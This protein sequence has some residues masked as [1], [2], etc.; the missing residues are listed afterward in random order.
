MKFEKEK[1]IKEDNLK[2]KEKKDFLQSKL[3]FSG[4]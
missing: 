4:L 2:L 3:L 1:S